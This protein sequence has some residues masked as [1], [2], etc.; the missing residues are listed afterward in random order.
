MYKER[1]QDSSPFMKI[2]LNDLEKTLQR[3]VIL[4]NAAK[5]CFLH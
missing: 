3:S 2:K 1:E 5:D 4:N